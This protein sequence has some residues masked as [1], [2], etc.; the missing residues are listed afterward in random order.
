MALVRQPDPVWRA[1]QA[2]EREITL[3]TTK[4]GREIPIDEMGDDHIANAMRVLSLWRTRLKKRDSTH[5][6][7]RQL[8]DAI[9][10]FKRIQRQRLKALPRAKPDVAHPASRSSSFAARRPR[11]PVANT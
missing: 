3:W 6:M 4:D 8:A 9:T 11:K 5:D 10:R 7:I 1:A 2:A